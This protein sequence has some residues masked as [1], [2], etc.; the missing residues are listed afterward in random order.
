LN[1][2]TTKQTDLKRFLSKLNRL[3]IYRH[4]QKRRNGKANLESSNNGYFESIEY[5]RH[6]FFIEKRRAER[7]NYEFS[8]II[9]D[10]KDDVK[11]FNR[12]TNNALLK[13]ED[14]LFSTIIMVLRSTDI[15][16]KYCPFKLAILL[17]D[18][19]K[20]GTALVVQRINS[21]LNEIFDLSHG[22]ILKILKIDSYCYPEH[23]DEIDKL[24]E[25][26]IITE[27][28][29][30]IAVEKTIREVRS[31]YFKTKHSNGYSKKLKLNTSLTNTLVL[32]NPFFLLNEVFF[33]FPVNWHKIFKRYVDISI[34]LLAIFFLSPIIFVITFLIKITSSGPVF[35]KQERIGYMGK[36][37]IIY[38]FR[39]MY[40]TKDERIHRDYVKDFITN[41]KH[42]EVEFNNHIFKITNDPRITPIG[43]FLRRTSLDEIG[44]FINVLKGD[45]SLV[46]PRPPIPYEVEMYDLWHKR[47]FL[48]VKPGITGLWQI[49]GR[50][51]I[52]FNEMVRLDLTYANNWSLSLDFKI[53]LKTL[54]AVLSMNG[55][56]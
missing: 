10:Q 42:S 3:N 15:V 11:K 41:N 48:T 21:E 19:E 8:L 18:T 1:L 16:V 20:E 9:I 52:T 50:N 47:R 45:M 38:K 2:K 40:Q 5:F 13:T 36:K 49:Y 34:S 30:T 25:S 29:S 7:K 26:E 56:Y 24:I 39:T 44:Q 6:R 28:N 43:K 31:H 32:E 27:K 37:F 33:D 51:T 17:P 54:W 4:L 53:L 14:V 35:F 12:G 23:A 55:A 22:D 46:G